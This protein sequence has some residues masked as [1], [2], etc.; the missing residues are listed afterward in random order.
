MF[1]IGTAN[2]ISRLPPEFTR[3][4]RLD[5][6]SFLDLPEA[7]ERQWGRKVTSVL[8]SCQLDVTN[9]FRSIRENSL[10]VSSNAIGGRSNAIAR[11]SHV[12]ISGLL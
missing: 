2:E 12:S 4:K 3:A 1:F 6:L 8:R 10:G 7:A 5:A 11:A 9:F